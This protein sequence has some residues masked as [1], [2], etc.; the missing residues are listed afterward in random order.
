MC[1]NERERQQKE[2]SRSSHERASKNCI[3]YFHRRPLSSSQTKK[4]RELLALAQFFSCTFCEQDHRTLKWNTKIWEKNDRA[5]E[6]ESSTELRARKSGH[7]RSFTYW[8]TV[9]HTRTHTHGFE[10]IDKSLVCDDERK[11]YA[12]LLFFHF[13]LPSCYWLVRDYLKLFFS[14]L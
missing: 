13:T 10:S 4:I 14:F 7:H 1:K 2:I 11:N 3:V 5:I 8:E 12:L 9:A 6:M